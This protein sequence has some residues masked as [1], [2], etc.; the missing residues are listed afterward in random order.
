MFVR[1]VDMIKIWQTL[2]HSTIGMR[3]WTFQTSKLRLITKFT[4]FAGPKYNLEKAM[5]YPVLNL[6]L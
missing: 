4:R 6:K 5:C 1:N 3:L 2:Q